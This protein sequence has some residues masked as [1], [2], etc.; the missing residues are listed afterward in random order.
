M[1]LLVLK[2]KSGE[3]W[4]L[5]LCM[6]VSIKV[7]SGFYVGYPRQHPP[8]ASIPSKEAKPP[9]PTAKNQPVYKV[10]HNK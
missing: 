7:L 6:L 8:S 10:R 3:T 2:E 9:Q 4:I 1:R 5:V